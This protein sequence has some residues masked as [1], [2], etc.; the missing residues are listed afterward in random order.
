VAMK[1]VAYSNFRKKA[2]WKKMKSPSSMR[3]GRFHPSKCRGKVQKMEVLYTHSPKIQGQSPN[4]L[5][6]PKKKKVNQKIAKK[7]GGRELPVV[8]QTTGHDRRATSSRLPLLR[9]CPKCPPC[10]IFLLLPAHLF[11]HMWSTLASWL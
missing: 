8:Y 10:K 1:V 5:T 2:F 7:G 9:G 11:L 6:T 4:F 3:N